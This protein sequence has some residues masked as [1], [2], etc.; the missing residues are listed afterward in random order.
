LINKFTNKYICLFVYNLFHVRRL[1]TKDD[2]ALKGTWI[3]NDK[4]PLS[5]SVVTKWRSRSW[6]TSNVVLNAAFAVERLQFGTTTT[7]S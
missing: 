3:R 7:H 4:E 6:V 5:K 1:E 2:Y